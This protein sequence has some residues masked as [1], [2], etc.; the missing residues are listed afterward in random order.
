MATKNREKSLIVMVADSTADLTRV[1][2]SETL[3]HTRVP[4]VDNINVEMCSS[5]VEVKEGK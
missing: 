2:S 5:S 3:S 4:W 1:Q